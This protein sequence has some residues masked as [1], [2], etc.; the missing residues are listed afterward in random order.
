M[1]SYARRCYALVLA[2]LAMGVGF[3]GAM[4]ARG[5]A[6]LAGQA[7]A[8]AGPDALLLT[9]FLYFTGFSL[10]YL[11]VSLPLSFYGGYVL[12]HQFGL[13]TQTLGRWARRRLKKWLYSFIVAAPLV[14]IFYAMLRQWPRTWWVPAAAAWIFVAYVLTKF[15]PRILIPIFYKL[16][17]VDD[18]ALS[19]RLSELAA[20]AGIKLAAVCRI[21]LSRETKKANAAVVGMGSTRRVVLGDTLLASFS[22]D[23]IAAVFAH[24]LGHV[25]HKDLVKGFVLAG[26]LSAGS[27]YAGSVALGSSS[28][29]LD[30]T[31]VYDPETLPILIAVLAAIQLLVLP[32]EK[33]YS[34]RREL[35]SDRY[36]LVSTGARE[37]FISAMRKLGAMNLADVRPNRLAEIFLFSHP[38]ISKR[39]RFAATLDLG[40]AK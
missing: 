11:L 9:V 14:L 7:R 2:H 34:R 5:S 8:I 29:A 4:M 39:I 25:V 3:I 23:E 6:A 35:E 16:E 15:A 21:D 1:R 12:E 37:P 31:H 13:S 38:P 20:N 36:A 10:A 17:A 30:I 24:E 18:E 22:H 27:L 33:W 32:L 40:A 28:A 26:I 19:A